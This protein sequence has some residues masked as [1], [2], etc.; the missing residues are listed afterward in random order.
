MVAEAPCLEL[1]FLIDTVIVEVA[2]PNHPFGVRG[3]GETSVIPPL[4]AV[5]NAV[6]HAIGVRMNSL[7]LS[8]GRILE[9]LWQK[10]GS[11]G[12]NGR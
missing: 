5:T 10:N 3:V 6:S 8:P 9:A 4:A 2:N 11:N 12:T 7:P 1:A